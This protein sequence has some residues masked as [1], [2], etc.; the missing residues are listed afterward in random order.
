MKRVRHWLEKVISTDYIEQNE[1]ASQNSTLGTN[2]NDILDDEYDLLTDEKELKTGERSYA[3]AHRA[4][5]LFQWEIHR[6]MQQH[7]LILTRLELDLYV[8]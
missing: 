5:P 6:K 8:L 1:Y 2:F 7:N 3:E 4:L